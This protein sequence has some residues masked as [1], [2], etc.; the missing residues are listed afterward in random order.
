MALIVIS[1]DRGGLPPHT[2]DQ[3]EEWVEF[4]VGQRGGISQDNPLADIDMEARV[5]EISA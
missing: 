5:R 4:N 1:I 3:F 2:S